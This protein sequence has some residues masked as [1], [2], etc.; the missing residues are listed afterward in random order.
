MHLLQQINDPVLLLTAG[1]PVC[2]SGLSTPWLRA[3]GQNLGWLFR[4][5]SCEC[6]TPGF[7]CRIPRM[8]VTVGFDVL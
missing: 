1:G 7:R 4:G 8:P 5:N 3:T 2:T 6:K